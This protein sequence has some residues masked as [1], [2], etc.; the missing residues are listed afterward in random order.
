MRHMI[1]GFAACAALLGLAPTTSAVVAQTVMGAS[2]PRVRIERVRGAGR[3]VKGE[4]RTFRNDTLEVQR[5]PGETTIVLVSQVHKVAISRGYARRPLA[6]AAGGAFLGAMIGGIRYVR[7]NDPFQLAQGDLAATD[8]RNRTD[9]SL[10]CTFADARHLKF[11]FSGAG[12][13]ALIGAAAGAVLGAIIPFEQ[14]RTV[15]VSAL[16]TRRFTARPV[17]SLRGVGVRVVF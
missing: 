17:L 10:L 13:G 15:S 4:L 5:R 3:T 2:N 14:W 1:A 9:N 16:E 12:R 11:S 7:A 8:C 6:M